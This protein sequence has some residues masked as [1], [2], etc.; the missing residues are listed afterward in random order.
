[1]FE[2]LTLYSEFLE[3]G[4]GASSVV[5]NAVH[6]LTR[7]RVAVKVI[8]KT[9]LNEEGLKLA[10]RESERLREIDHPLIV[11]LYETIETEQ[12]LYVIMEIIKGQTLLDYLNSSGPFKEDHVKEIFGQIVLAVSYLHSKGVVHRDLKLENIVLMK[13][14]IVRLLDFGFSREI[15]DGALMNTFCGSIHYAA[16]ELFLR[17]PYSKEVDVWSL[18]VIL[19]ALVSNRFPFDAQGNVNKQIELT[20]KGVMAPVD[21]ISADLQT[22]FSTIFEKDRLSRATINDIMDSAWLQKGGYM[23]FMRSRI[24]AGSL[25]VEPK[26]EEEID[27]EIVRTVS[28]NTKVTANDVINMLLRR[29]TNSSTVSYRIMRTKAVECTIRHIQE[30]WSESGRQLVSHAVSAHCMADLQRGM[31]KM[32]GIAPVFSMRKRRVSKFTFIDGTVSG[33]RTMPPKSEEH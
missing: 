3:I 22:L 32:G 1:M 16:P 4:H 2:P 26:S 7:K 15:E 11:H 20:V 18:G 29:S 21:G 10:R 12:F 8:D 28:Q 19:Y 9:K 6:V 23:R 5:Y 25:R 31:A 33:N 27:R 24:C 13:G 30:T 17:Q 14:N